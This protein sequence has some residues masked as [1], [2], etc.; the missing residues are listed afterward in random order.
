VSD[1]AANFRWPGATILALAIAAVVLIAAIQFAYHARI[2]LSEWSDR[3]DRKESRVPS[4]GNGHNDTNTQQI[5]QNDDYS[6][7]LAWTRRTRW[8][9]DIG[10]VSLLAGLC[11]AVAPFH[12]NGTE[13]FLRGLASGLAI[14]ACALELGWT[15]VDPLL[16]AGRAKQ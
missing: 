3:E 10:L 4:Q 2:A 5:Q 12:V 8:A 11:L 7:G 9:Y 1:D 14:I 6:R 16:R 15:V 13:A